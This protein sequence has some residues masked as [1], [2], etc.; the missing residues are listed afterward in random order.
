MAN[1]NPGRFSSED[2]LYM[3]NHVFLPPKL[4]QADD[5]NRDRDIALCRLVHDA[6]LEFAGFL[7]QPQQQQWS[8]VNKM[9]RTQLKIAQVVDKDVLAKDILSLK[10]GGQSCQHCA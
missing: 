2:L 10:D 8:I 4:P 9:L 7:S 3:L 1:R 5:T 6:S